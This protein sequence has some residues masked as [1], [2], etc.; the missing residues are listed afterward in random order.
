MTNWKKEVGVSRGLAKLEGK[1]DWMRRDEE[2][3]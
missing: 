3:L 1:K 2:A